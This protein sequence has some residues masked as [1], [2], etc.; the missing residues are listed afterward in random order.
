MDETLVAFRI[1]SAVFWRFRGDV[2]DREQLQS[3]VGAEGLLLG[4]TSPRCAVVYRRSREKGIDPIGACDLGGV[5]R[6]K[7]NRGQMA[8]VGEDLV[9]PQPIG[10]T[11]AVTSRY[12]DR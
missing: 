9:Q 3:H 2:R 8:P 11:H 6:K 5:Y 4:A 1:R 7:P 10:R 12:G